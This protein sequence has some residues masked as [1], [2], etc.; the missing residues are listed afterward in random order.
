[1]N[2]QDMVCI[3]L[4]IGIWGGR[5]R[6]TQGDLGLS[7]EILPPEAVASLGSKR[8]FPR[9]P[10]DA[11]HALR[12]RIERSFQRMG[13]RFM[14]GFA[15]PAAVK[16]EVAEMLHEYQKEFGRLIDTLLCDYGRSLD[17]FVTGYPK[18]KGM[19]LS[20]ALR[21]EDTRSRF[22]FRYQVTQIMV[23]EGMEDTSGV[24]EA[25]EA[26]PK[27]VFLDVAGQGSAILRSLGNRQ[28]AVS[29]RTVGPLKAAWGK[30]VALSFLDRNIVPVAS[31]LEAIIESLPKSGAF[32]DA[33]CELLR[34]TAAVLADT[35]INAD[36]ARYPVPGARPV[37]AKP[38]ETFRVQRRQ[39]LGV[40][41]AFDW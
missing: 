14:G 16:D 34:K 13:V 31:R 8:I 1:M 7:A 26:L 35:G 19:V 20:A 41:H 30:L 24:K 38:V 4:D 21:P 12:T 33:D 39:P 27:Q 6:L 28:A 25:V 22:H 10:L 23:P 9:E 5:K 18:W 37:R 40:I 32:Q 29:V 17:D 36:P 11:F 2:L 3:H 15:V